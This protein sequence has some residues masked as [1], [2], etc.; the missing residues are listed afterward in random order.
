MDP[1]R[2]WD[3]YC[4]YKANL[5][6]F[7]SSIHNI[8]V[9]QKAVD[10]YKPHFKTTLSEEEVDLDPFQYFLRS[11][12]FEDPSNDRKL[13]DYMGVYGVGLPDPTTYMGATKYTLA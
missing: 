12:V 5:I 13:V 10:F 8:D 2:Y 4:A 3:N 9:N 1:F 6:K 11:K 7:L